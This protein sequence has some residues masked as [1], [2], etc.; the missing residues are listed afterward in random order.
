MNRGCIALN[1]LNCDS[2][3]DTVEAGEKYLLVDEK[4]KISRLCVDCC[5]K[6]KLAAYKT[7]KGEKILTFL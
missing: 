3:G 5:V 7:E 6:K 4:Q 1:E 2:C